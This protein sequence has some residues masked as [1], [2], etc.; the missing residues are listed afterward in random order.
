MHALPEAMSS[1][2]STQLHGSP[3]S[4]SSSELQAYRHP[5]QPADAVA[6]RSHCSSGSTLMLPQREDTQVPPRHVPPSQATPSF[7]TYRQRELSHVTLEHGSGGHAM[8]GPHSAKHEGQS[9][10]DALPGSQT[11]PAATSTKPSPQR[12][13]SQASRTQISATPPLLHGS[14]SAWPRHGVK[15]DASSGSASSRS[16]SSRS[17][18]TSTPSTPASARGGPKSARR[19]QP[20]PTQRMA[21]ARKKML[22]SL[23]GK[24]MRMGRS[25]AFI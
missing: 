23:A 22:V 8:L 20:L 25:C 19:P 3:S 24:K 13:A 12:D 2:V 10:S 7:G 17:A 5:M 16:A 1:Q 18:S 11:S 15:P 4:Q 6:P 14:P 21:N 9:G